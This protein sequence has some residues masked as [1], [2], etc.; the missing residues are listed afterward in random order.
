MPTVFASN[1]SGLSLFLDFFLGHKSRTRQAKSN[2]QWI[3]LRLMELSRLSP[4]HGA[5]KS[6]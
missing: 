3:N 4:P 6:Q 5:R 2:G 1:P